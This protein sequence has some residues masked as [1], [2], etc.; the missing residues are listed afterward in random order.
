MKAENP[1]LRLPEQVDDWDGFRGHPQG[2]P[3]PVCLLPKANKHRNC[4]VHRTDSR[5]HQKKGL[6]DAD[7][8]LL[9]KM[10]KIP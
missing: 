3:Q 7:A 8:D 9:A 6:V 10:N 2:N 5:S 1:D 4:F